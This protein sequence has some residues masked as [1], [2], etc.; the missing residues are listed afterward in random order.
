VLVLCCRI[1][2]GHPSLPGS[3]GAP[4]S[5]RPGSGWSPRCQASG[6]R[7][8]WTP[9]SLSRSAARHMPPMPC[10]PGWPART[11]SATRPAGLPSGPRSAPSALGMAGQVAYHGLAQAGAARAPWPITTLVSCLPV[12]VLAMGTA[13]AYMLRADAR[14][15]AGTTGPATPRSSAWFPSTPPR[16]RVEG[17]STTP[18]T[19]G[20]ARQTGPQDRRYNESPN[21]LA[22]TLNAELTTAIRGS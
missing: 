3:P 22:R 6:P 7:S 14:P 21:A 17:T 15:Y 4:P 13:L 11:G 20:P 10:A 12:L 5:R 18:R 1:T 2:A 19:A 9:R 8:T 16:T